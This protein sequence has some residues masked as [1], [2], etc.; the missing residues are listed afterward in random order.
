M[1][2]VASKIC[3]VAISLATLLSCGNSNRDQATQL[4]EAA[5]QEVKAGRYEGAM[6]LLD[7]LDTKYASEV[8]VR[9]SAMKFRAMAVEGLTLRRITAVDDT[10]AYLK[11]ISDQ[12]DQRFDY[13]ENPG[14]GL[15]GNYVAK[16]LVKGKPELLP[17]INDEGYFT[18]SVKVDG[19]PIGFSY[20]TFSDGSESV[21]TVPV[22]SSRL[23]KVENTEMTVLQQED[24]TEAAQWLVLHPDA[25]A[26]ELVGANSVLKRKL[27]PELR[28]AIVE[29]WQFAEAKQA[30]RLSLIEREKLE[31]R[32]QLC[33]DQLANVIDR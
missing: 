7:T 10:L 28:D 30:Y 20:I 32:L 1:L 14:K 6:M 17:R 23:V 16:S 21:S 2:N 12:F 11:S 26:Y 25:N 5:E 27:T 4:C 9:R 33:R 31:R 3:A 8:E 19:R 13:V 24:L 15:G 29:T 18:L 22:S